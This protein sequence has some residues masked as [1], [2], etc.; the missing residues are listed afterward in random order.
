MRMTANVAG[1]TF[2]FKEDA[3]LKLARP[4]GQVQLVGDP[5]NSYD[6]KAV[7]VMQGDAFF[8]FLQKDH[9]AQK[10]FWEDGVTLTAE[11][12]S[13][14]YFDKTQPKGSQFNEEH[15]GR[16][17]SITLSITDGNEETCAPATGT[18]AVVI[19][20]SSYT[21]DGKKFMRCTKVTEAFQ[22][23]GMARLIEWAYKE[24]PSG[25]AEYKAGMALLADEGTGNH[26]AIEKFLNGDTSVEIPHGARNFIEKYKPVVIGTECTV[27]DE[28]TLTAGTFDL[29]CTIEGV[30][31][32]VDWKRAKAVRP[33]MVMQGSFYATM[34]DAPQVMIV[35]LG[36]KT[37]QGYSLRTI[38]EEKITVEYEKF[39]MLRELLRL[40]QGW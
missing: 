20:H 15:I 37:V 24:F 33:S 32:I 30:P 11:I 3:S 22:P 25:Y 21:T 12:Q 4:Q 29:L 23:G 1:L 35:A 34:K 17:G 2:R 36:A 6:A 40:T 38:G 8:G 28:D 13:Y 18:P 16:L 5:T 9:P 39:C 7:K 31:T 10:M 19:D 27:Y 26:D 14:S